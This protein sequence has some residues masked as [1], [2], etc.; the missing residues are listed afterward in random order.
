LY[1]EYNL[2]HV[3]YVEA[4][5]PRKPSGTAK[6]VLTCIRCGNYSNYHDERIKVAEEEE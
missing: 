1:S 3:S 2:L 6:C 5:D 4:S